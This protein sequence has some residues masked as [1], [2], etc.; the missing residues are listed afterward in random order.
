MRTCGACASRSPISLKPSL[1]RCATGGS[2][3]SISAR[4]GRSPARSA[5]DGARAVV[6]ARH[7]V[8]AREREG[9]ALVDQR[10][11]VDQQQARLL[12]PRDYR[13]GPGREAARI[14]LLSDA[15][16]PPRVSETL[17]DVDSVTFSY[18]RRP[19]L[20][21]I[22]MQVPRGKVVAI[23]GVQRLRQDHAAA[24][25]RRAAAPG[26][27]RGARRRRARCTSSTARASTGCAGA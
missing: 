10:V 14:A 17:V 18:G 16:I 22:S 5:F 23:M 19:V 15:A 11:V 4:S 27:G 21:G 13:G 20:K 6:G 24:P 8:V 1:G 25:D 3:R 26:S 9:E 12:H 2:P 7:L